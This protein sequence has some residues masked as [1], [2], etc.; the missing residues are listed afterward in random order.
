METTGAAK[1]TTK[2]NVLNKGTEKTVKSK[3]NKRAAWSRNLLVLGT[4]V[5]GA[6]LA[7]AQSKVS[8]DLQNAVTL[9][10][11][12]STAAASVAASAST[13]SNAAMI[14]QAAASV[15]ALANPSVNVIVQYSG[16][17]SQTNYSAATSAGA[18][19]TGQYS[20]FNGA[21]YSIHLSAVNTLVA[22]DPTISYVSLDRP[23]SGASDYGDGTQAIGLDIARNYGFDGTGVGVAVIDSGIS[24]NR[25]LTVGTSAVSR[26]VY[27]Q[28]FVAGTTS[29]ADAYGHGTHVAGIL[30]GNGYNST[31]THCTVTFRGVA[32][33]VKLINLRALDQNGSGTDSSVIAAIDRAIALKSTYNIRVINLSIG[34]GI[35]ESYKQDPLCQEVEKAWKAGIVVV[36]AAGNYGRDNSVGEEGYGTITSPGNDP[37]VITVGAMKSMYTDTP[38]D[39]LIATYSSKGPSAV[40]HIVK[41]DVVAA[42]NGRV[43][44]LASTSATLYANNPTTAVANN[45]Y[46]SGA[47]SSAS[48]NYYRL[49]GTSM[50]TP[51]V[52]GAAA[53][54][55]QQNSKLTPDQVK[56]RL[57]KTTTKN[58][59]A[60]STYTDPTTNTTYVDEYDI[61]TVGAGY[62]NV[63]DALNSTDL[64]SATVGSAQSPTAVYNSSTGVVTLVNQASSVVWGGSVL[65]GNSVIWGSSVSGNSVLWG[66]SAVNSN[67]VLWGASATAD[68]VIW[69]SSVLWGN[70]VL[71][72]GDK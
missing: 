14:T 67:S 46:Q 30:G 31:C 59:P 35:Y 26:I 58:F 12:V 32:P 64:A 36:V 69:G 39:D 47:T 41:P 24:A 19:L 3:L 8:P 16:T 33:G 65:W 68:S 27:N 21:N 40:D 25:D 38:A 23:L 2:I 55:L 57:M 43:S 56:A 34:R 50:A 45:Y 28:N 52:S 42:G 22:S 9:S 54:M 7:F 61:F 72:G 66:A 44:L 13:S 62:L 53:L 20:S 5:L 70:S 18:T 49:S 71:T 6:S 29:T 1:T 60:S 4:L 10:S 37:Y 15:T 11:A 48:S 63:A 17:P 51:E